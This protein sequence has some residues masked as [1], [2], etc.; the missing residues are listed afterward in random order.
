MVLDSPAGAGRPTPPITS[1]RGSAQVVDRNPRVPRAVSLRCAGGGG[2]PGRTRTCNLRIRSKTRPVRLV[3]S[4]RI[5]AAECGPQSDRSHPG[6]LRCNDRIAKQI[7]SM[8]ARGL[9]E[10]GA[11]A[12]DARLDQPDFRVGSC[13]VELAGCARFHSS[14][15]SSARRT[16]RSSSSALRRSSVT[17][18]QTCRLARA[19]AACPHAFARSGRP[20]STSARRSFSQRTSASARSIT[21]SPRPLTNALPL[22]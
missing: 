18:Q 9:P 20:F 19:S 2:A 11:G 14:P 3:L 6:R 5:A 21:A 16:A 7:A 10:H 22:P 15:R 8:T 1:T 12:S 17:D 13:R 4:L